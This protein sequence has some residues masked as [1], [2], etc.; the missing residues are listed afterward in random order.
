MKMPTQRGLPARLIVIPA[1]VFLAAIPGAAEPTPEQLAGMKEYRRHAPKHGCLC[2]SVMKPSAESAVV[3]NDLDGAPVLTARLFENKPRLSC[4]AVSG[5][6]LW[7]ADDRAVYEVDARKR[8]LGRA[9]TPSNGLADA[10]VRQL[11]ADDTSLWIVGAGAV[12]R[13]DL[14]TG[15]VRRTRCLTFE[16]GHVATGAAGTF[17]VTDA[18]AYRWNAAA[19]AMEPLGDYPGRERAAKAAA[20]GFWEVQWREHWSSMLRG[21]AVGEKGLWIVAGNT[22]S[23]FDGASWAVLSQRAWKLAVTGSDVYALTTTGL[24]RCDDRTGQVTHLEGPSGPTPGRPAA[25]TLAPDAAYVSVEAQARSG[26]LAGGGISRFDPKSG[27]WDHVDEIGKTEIRLPTTAT[28]DGT[29]LFVGVQVAR[30]VEKRSLHPGMARVKRSVPR[31]GGLTVAVRTASGDW[32]ALGIQGI[33]GQ[34]RWVLGQQNKQSADR[35]FPQRIAQLLSCKG[36]LWAITEDYPEHW[37]GGYTHGVRCVAHCEDGHWTAVAD[38][39]RTE[40]VGL[41]GEQP[42]IVCLT[43]THGSPVVLAHGHRRVL[44]LAA[45]GG[46]TWI[47]HEGGAYFYD[48]EDDRFRSVKVEPFRAY[49]QVTAADCDDAALWLGTDAGTITRYDNT[50]GRFELLG[51]CPQRKIERIR[52]ADGK[53]WVET[54][55]GQASPP[56][57]LRD[58]PRLG[59]A[60][61]ST[62]VYDGETWSAGGKGEMPAARTTGYRFDKRGYLVTAGRDRRVGFVRGVFE[63]KV[64]CVEEDGALWIKVWGGIGRL[65]LNRTQGNTAG[66]PEGRP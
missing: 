13:M 33:G 37:Y 63:P 9:I 56:R 40:S 29:S 2:C 7:A 55:P 53:V 15:H 57:P 5:D 50:S 28:F 65:T 62:L 30:G 17:L 48:E 11:V 51:C 22:L 4:F 10:P 66:Q 45:C 34:K 59:P 46:T 47:V 38:R 24:L 43:A 36:R 32:Q 8:R 42:G 19:E 60:R 64:L 44:G 27:T 21:A 20:R 12:S 14:S 6:R 3:P 25:L 18:G 1:A 54:A 49:W 31:V 52:V 39:D 58:L 41:A 16:V 35:V 23:R 61:A 26:R